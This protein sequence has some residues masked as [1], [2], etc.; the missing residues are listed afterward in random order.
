M[1]IYNEFSLSSLLLYVIMY[2]CRNKR[3]GPLRHRVFLHNLTFFYAQ[4]LFSISIIT[5]VVQKFY[6][7]VSYVCTQFYLI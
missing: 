4:S 7:T 1:Y 2:W 3:F 6:Y 5:R